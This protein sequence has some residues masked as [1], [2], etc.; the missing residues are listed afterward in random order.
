MLYIDVHSSDLR[1]EQCSELLVLF[2]VISD[3]APFC[4][5]MTTN[6]LLYDD[7][8]VL[9]IPMCT[10]VIVVYKYS[11]LFQYTRTVERGLKCRGIVP[12]PEAQNI[13]RHKDRMIEH[14]EHQCITCN[15]QHKICYICLHHTICIM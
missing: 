9:C 6:A 1:G 4:L 13:V 3:P 12:L 15:I 14:K 8:S 5:K 2:H 11:R 7:I 10:L